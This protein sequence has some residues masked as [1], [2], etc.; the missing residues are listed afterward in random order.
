M[1]TLS[2]PVKMDLYSTE[3][4]RQKQS[5]IDRYLSTRYLYSTNSRREAAKFERKQLIRK[6]AA[7]LARLSEE[8]TRCQHIYL[9]CIH[10]AGSAH[11]LAQ[12]IE[13][14]EQIA[15]SN[16]KSSQKSNSHGNDSVY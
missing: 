13:K 11:R 16:A 3:R 7:A 2:K 10:Q 6:R 8:L 5:R 4:E 15:V 14:V 12:L 1:I 9:N